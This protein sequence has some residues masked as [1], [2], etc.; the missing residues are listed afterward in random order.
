MKSLYFT[1]FNFKKIFLRV[2]YLSYER[3]FN[4]NKKTNQILMAIFD[5]VIGILLLV[6][7]ASTFNQMMNIIVTVY[8]IYLIVIGV[9]YI[10]NK[11]VLN[12][13]V[14]ILCG[15]LLLCLGWTNIA[16]VAT[17]ILGIYLIIISFYTSFAILR[18]FRIS[19]LLTCLIGVLL[20]MI[21]FGSHFAWSFANIFFY[22]C[23]AFIL[24]RGI[25]NL[26]NL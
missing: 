7:G 3:I 26:F 20:V 6:G 2:K 23:G 13:V 15:I 24:V 25:L 18:I 10:L 12:G 1:I 9:F 16:W 19:S 4:M 11:N 8:A 22:I 5:I 17:F 14:D 21:S